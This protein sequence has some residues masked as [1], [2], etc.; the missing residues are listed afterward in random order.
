MVPIPILPVA[1]ITTGV[2]SGLVESSTTRALPEPVWVI[3]S[4]SEELLSTTFN[5]APGFVVP[6]PTEPLKY[7]SL[8]TWSCWDCK[9]P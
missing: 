1:L 2:E 5:F 7:P 8:L 6:I 3:L 9:V 4:A